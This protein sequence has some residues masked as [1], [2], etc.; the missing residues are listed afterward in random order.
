MN[1]FVVLSILLIIAIIVSTN[2][3]KKRNRNMDMNKLKSKNIQRL[4]KIESPQI[5]V[6]IVDNSR[7]NPRD[8]PRSGKH[9]FLNNMILDPQVSKHAGK[10]VEN[11]YKD[12]LKEWNGIIKN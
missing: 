2:P 10:F 4:N 9:K 12:I 1:K 8:N 6:N 7:D 3:P 11:R 5:S